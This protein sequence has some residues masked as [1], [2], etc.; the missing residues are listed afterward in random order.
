MKLHKTWNE[1]EWGK[2]LHPRLRA[3]PPWLYE[4]LGIVL[5]ILIVVCIVAWVIDGER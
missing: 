1:V 3:L 2:N 5:A 4:C